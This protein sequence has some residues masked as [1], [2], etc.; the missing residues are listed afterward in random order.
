MVYCPGTHLSRQRRRCTIEI[1]IIDYGRGNIFS[2]ANALRHLG[3]TP[4]LVSDPQELARYS[5][6]ILP[7]VGSFGDAMRRLEATG[8]ADAIPA[9]VATDRPL[10]GICLGMQVLLTDGDEGGLRPGLGLIDGRVRQLAAPGLKIPHVGWNT[11]DFAPA[12]APLVTGLSRSEHF[13]FVHSYAA[14]PA[15]PAAWQGVCCYGERFAAV[16]GSANLWGTQFHPEKSGRAGL[17]L[18]ANFLALPGGATP[19]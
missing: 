16:V 5:H 7:G 3:A 9:F 11:V 18:L 13:Y 4:R 15:G 17:A 10:L 12:A 1:A 6:A 19:C 2:V 8:M 14:F